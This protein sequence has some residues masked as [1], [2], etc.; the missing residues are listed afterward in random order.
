[1]EVSIESDECAALDCLAEGYMFVVVDA[2][3]KAD[4]KIDPAVVW[5]HIADLHPNWQLAPEQRRCQ[6]DGLARLDRA[7]WVG[8]D[9]RRVGPLP[10]PLRGAQYAPHAIG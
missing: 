9:I 10:E 2:E 7:N 8:R 1:M 4:H 5:V 3:W 6:V